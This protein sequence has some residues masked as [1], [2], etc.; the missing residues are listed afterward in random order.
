VRIDNLT[1]INLYQS[2]GFAAVGEPR[3]HPLS[4]APMIEMRRRLHRA[5]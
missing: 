4:G 5:L 3:A 2:E 1:A